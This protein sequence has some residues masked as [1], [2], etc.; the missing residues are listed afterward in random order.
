MEGADSIWP[1]AAGK[2]EDTLLICFPQPLQPP[3]NST[4]PMQKG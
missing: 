1:G 3:Q 4:L 2:D